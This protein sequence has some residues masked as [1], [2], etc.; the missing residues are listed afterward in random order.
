MEL[1]K[2]EQHLYVKTATCH[3]RNAWKF[4]A[5]LQET[6]GKHRKPYRTVGRQVQAFKCGSVST[7][8]MH[9]NGRGC[10][11]VAVSEDCMDKDR[12]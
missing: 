4:Q 7:V 6:M 9:S 3:G 12:C 1:C 5:G 8:D 10:M 11:S 2:V